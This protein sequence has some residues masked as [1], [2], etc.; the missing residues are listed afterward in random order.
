M[1]ASRTCV[2]I[3]FAP[4]SRW[5]IMSPDKETKNH[6]RCFNPGRYLSATLERG[7][8]WRHRGAWRELSMH[9]ATI[10]GPRLWMRPNQSKARGEQV[11]IWIDRLASA[12]RCS[13]IID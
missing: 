1:D 8:F 2:V 5:G 11:L 9:D 6:Q 13:G 4:G 10:G 3:G 12:Y 7:C